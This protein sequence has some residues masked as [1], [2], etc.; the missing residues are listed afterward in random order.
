MF[1]ILLNCNED[2][3]RNNQIDYDPGCRYHEFCLILGRVALE[4]AKD[5]EAD[6]KKEPQLILESFFSEP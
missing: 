2:N 1:E 3:D 5:R 4:I 6:K